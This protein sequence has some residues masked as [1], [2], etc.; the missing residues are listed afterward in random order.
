MA[1]ISFDQ[2]QHSS[3]LERKHMISTLCNFKRWQGQCFQ[4]SGLIFFELWFWIS[5]AKLRY[6]QKHKACQVYE[7]VV[8]E[9][10]QWIVV[11][12][13]V[14]KVLCK[15]VS[16]LESVTQILPLLVVIYLFHRSTAPSSKQEA[17]L[18]CRKNDPAITVL[19]SVIM[20]Q[21]RHSSKQ[22]CSGKIK[23]FLDLDL[24]WL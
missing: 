15:I 18:K 2:T 9:N 24:L 7:D 12:T 21:H 3:L 8:R 11:Q 16:H 23:F 1:L 22:P 6:L 13:P 4:K 20:T 14:E 19:K 17:I 10:S 5:C